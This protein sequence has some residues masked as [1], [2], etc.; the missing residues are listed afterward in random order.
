MNLEAVLSAAGLVMG[1]VVKTTVFMTDLGRFDEMNQAYGWF[2]PKDP[3]AR[4][5]LGVLALPRG[6]LVAVEAVAGGA[7]PC[8]PG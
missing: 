1:D 8:G 6:S 4:S 3:P 2:F 7:E 5:T